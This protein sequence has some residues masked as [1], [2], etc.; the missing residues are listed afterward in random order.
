MTR[1]R[2][3][4]WNRTRRR[5][6]IVAALSAFLAAAIVTVGGVGNVYAYYSDTVGEAASATAGELDVTASGTVQQE[7]FADYLSEILGPLGGLVLPSQ[8][9]GLVP[10]DVS[11]TVTNNGTV[12]WTGDATFFDHFVNQGNE[13]VETG[14][15]QVFSEY[16]LVDVAKELIAGDADADIIAAD[17][18][19]GETMPDGAAAKGQTHDLGQ[20]SLAPGASTTLHYLA[21]VTPANGTVSSCSAPYLSGGNQVCD[22]Q[23]V[24]GLAIDAHGTNVGGTV[25]TGWVDSAD[26]TDSKVVTIKVNTPPVITATTTEDRTPFIGQIGASGQPTK[27]AYLAGLFTATDAEDGDLTSK[28]QVTSG[29]DPN[30]AGTYTATANVSDSQG[31]A[32]DP[33]SQTIQEWNFV[34]IAGG[35]YFDLALDSRGRVWGWGENSYGQV[36]PTGAGGNVALPQLVTGFPAGLTVV[37]MAAGYDTSWFAMSDGSVYVLG[38]GGDGEFGNGAY[39]SHTTPTAASLPA[40]VDILKVSAMGYSVAALAAN[41][42]V[43]TWGQGAYGQLGTG[44]DAN[45]TTPQKIASGVSDLSQGIWGGAL[46]RAG[47]LYHYGTDIEGEMGDGTPGGDDNPPT[48]VPNSPTNVVQVSVGQ[49]STIFRTSDNKVYV[50]GSNRDNRIGPGA[51]GDNWPITQVTATMN[52]SPID[53]H[54]GWDYSQIITSTG[55]LYAIGYNSYESLWIG[56][57]TSQTAWTHSGVFPSDAVKVVGYYDSDLALSADGSTLYTKGGSGY[58][59][60]GNNNSTGDLVGS[61]NGTASLTNIYNDGTVPDA[62]TATTSLKLSL[63]TVPDLPAT[64]PSDGP[65]ASTAPTTPA[66]TDEGSSTDGATDDTTD[67]DAG[68]ASDDAASASDDGTDGTSDEDGTTTTSPSAE[69]DGDQG[70]E[71]V[72]PLSSAAPRPEGDSGAEQPS[73]A[74]PTGTS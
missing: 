7:N 65:T 56:S 50:Y 59:V 70:S 48:L 22:L 39:G 16:D 51:T 52:G 68:T 35:Q 36:G 43:Y 72:A 40:G 67:D 60:L 5:A 8:L 32:A 3:R 57:S 9:T 33:V 42:D 31:A 74:E 37:S 47:A 12:P 10:Y 26:G 53:V 63:G 1:G 73:V 66:T 28:V 17:Q 49:Y 41:G 46:V 19:S 29:F 27:A 69:A 14:M 71:S 6:G 23:L 64:E 34:D 45:Q 11:F 25:T 54:T 4:G 58:G 30:V 55:D 15:V 2:H 38:Y 62:T 20:V 44:G 13:I 24:F 18:P 61:T 21:L